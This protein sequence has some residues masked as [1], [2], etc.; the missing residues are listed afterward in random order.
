M[1]MKSPLA[2]TNAVSQPVIIPPEAEII[3]RGHIS[4]DVMERS[5]LIIT[6]T[7]SKKPLIHASQLNVGTHITAMGSDTY[8]KQELDPKILSKADIGREEAATG[9]LGGIRNRPTGL[10]TVPA[11]ACFRGILS[12]L[13]LF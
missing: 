10:G 5:N 8:D 3:I 2:V 7:P 13:W 9:I 11:K 12:L 4:H 1:R 6:S